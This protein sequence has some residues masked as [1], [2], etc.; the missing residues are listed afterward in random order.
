MNPEEASIIEIKMD[1]LDDEINEVDEQL[2]VTDETITGL[3]AAPSQLLHIEMTTQRMAIDR[4]QSTIMKMNF[5][6]DRAGSISFS[7][8]GPLYD[9]VSPHLR[10]HL[11]CFQFSKIH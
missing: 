11:P 8:L 5:S 6:A 9:F 7:V 4:V 3:I 10:L 1:E 2:T